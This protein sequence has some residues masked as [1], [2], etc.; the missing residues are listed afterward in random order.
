MGS[1]GGFGSL[2]TFLKVPQL[3]ATSSISSY[4]RSSQAFIEEL[5]VRSQNPGEKNKNNYPD[6]LTTVS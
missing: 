4:N 3:I 2:I 1:V 5:G 6:L